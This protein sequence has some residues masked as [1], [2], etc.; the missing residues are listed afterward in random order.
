MIY[1]NHHRIHLKLIDVEKNVYNQVKYLNFF[2]SSLSNMFSFIF[3]EKNSMRVKKSAEFINDDD[4]DDD[5]QS[6]MDVAD[7]IEIVTTGMESK[8]EQVYVK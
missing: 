6:S 3:K 2:F 5:D 7:T 4:D 8:F 1:R